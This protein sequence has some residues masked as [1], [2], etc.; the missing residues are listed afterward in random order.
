VKLFILRKTIF[1][2]K[3]QVKSDF[4]ILGKGGDIPMVG[5]RISLRGEVL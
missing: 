3:I 2:E 1:K 5:G 4:K